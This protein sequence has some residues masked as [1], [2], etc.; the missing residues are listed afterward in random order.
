M[1][2]CFSHSSIDVLLLGLRNEEWDPEKY[3]YETQKKGN[4]C[5]VAMGSQA[6]HRSFK[7]DNK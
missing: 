3:G 7:N 2:C 4:I 6:S 5:I 1:F